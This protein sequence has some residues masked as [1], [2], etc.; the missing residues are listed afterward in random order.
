MSYAGHEH[1]ITEA[2]GPCGRP[3]YEHP[4]SLMV[5]DSIGFSRFR[6]SATAS[7]AGNNTLNEPGK[8]ENF[9]RAH[10][11]RMTLG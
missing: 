6:G 3:A 9:A 8:C 2:T 11:A 4:V 7:A 1:S 5:H 10:D